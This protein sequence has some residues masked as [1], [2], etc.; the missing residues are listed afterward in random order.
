[1]FCFPEGAVTADR[2]PKPNSITEKLLI[3]KTNI[4]LSLLLMQN[5]CLSK[6][7]KNSSTVINNQVKL[8]MSYFT[9]TIPNRQHCSQ[10]EQNHIWIKKKLF[11]EH[12]SFVPS[13][14]LAFQLRYEAVGNGE[15]RKKNM[16]N[17]KQIVVKCLNFKTCCLVD[18]L[19]RERGRK[20]LRG[21]NGGGA[22]R[23]TAKLWAIIRLPNINHQ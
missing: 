12:K 3:M 9:A 6:Q 5:L 21:E 22:T 16:S 7:K 20:A 19:S 4:R 10:G 13:L 15:Q 11:H 1:M 17:K 18:S 8:S 14:F 23:T 2:F